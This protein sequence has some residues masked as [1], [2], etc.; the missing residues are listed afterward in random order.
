MELGWLLGLAV[1]DLE[2]PLRAE[3]PRAEPERIVLLGPRDLAELTEADVASVADRVTIDDDAAVRADPSGRARRAMSAV[4]RA[5]ASWWLHVDLDVLS[6][7]ALPAVDYQQTGGL[8]W[9]DLDAVTA[10]ALD[11]GGCAGMSVTIYDPDLDP[12]TRHAPRIATFVATL[13][14][15]V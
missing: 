6:T 8:S 3:I 7:E 15:R 12:D 9:D 2:A 14:A 4:A 11:H 5:G 10:T 1:D 13:A